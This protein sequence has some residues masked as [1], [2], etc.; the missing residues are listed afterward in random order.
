MY[1]PNDKKQNSLPHTP[2]VDKNYKF[3]GFGTNQSKFNKVYKVLEPR[4]YNYG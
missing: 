3:K 4:L 1:I 2:F